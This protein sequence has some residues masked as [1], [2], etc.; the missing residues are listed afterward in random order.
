MSDELLKLFV[1]GMPGSGKSTVAQEIARYLRDVHKRDTSY[2][3]DY[4]ILLKMYQEQHNR[5][6]P[7]EYGGFTI[8][9]PTIYN[10][11][12][13]KLKWQ[14]EEVERQA[15][16]DA[17]RLILIEFARSNY[18]Q[19][20]QFLGADFLIGASFLFLDVAVDTCMGRTLER[21]FKPECEKNKNDYFVPKSVFDRY[22]LS[23]NSKYLRCDFKAD[24]QVAEERLAIITNAYPLQE[25]HQELYKFVDTMVPVLAL[26]M[27]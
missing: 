15:A 13:Q 19:A 27:G 25:A 9:D 1:L 18:R 4:D 11:V 16:A 17:N 3:N 12:L 26:T 2:V 21:V 10:E 6:L 24:Y 23:N 22:R 20:F 5:F 7:A 8:A 14:V